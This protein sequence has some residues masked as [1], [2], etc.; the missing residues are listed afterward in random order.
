M[1]H[2]MS[3]FI[4]MYVWGVL[5]YAWHGEETA[6]ADN[7]QTYIH[8]YVRSYVCMYIYMPMKLAFFV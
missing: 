8:P 2:H 5:S 7:E 4:S 3:E 6:S 1:F